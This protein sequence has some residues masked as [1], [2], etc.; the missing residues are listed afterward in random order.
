MSHA[1]YSKTAMYSSHEIH[2]AKQ[3]SWLDGYV[4]ALAEMQGCS[5][6]YST[7]IDTYYSEAHIAVIFTYSLEQHRE[8]R[9]T[10]KTKQETNSVKGRGKRNRQPNS[11]FSILST[12]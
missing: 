1:R 11:H 7:H 10:M 12:P 2:Q 5:S 6:R 4:Q 8:I 3:C 9:E